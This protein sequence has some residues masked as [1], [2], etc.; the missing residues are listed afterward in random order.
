MNYRFAILDV[1]NGIAEIIKPIV[2]RKGVE[3]HYFLAAPQKGD[4][5]D[6]GKVCYMVLCCRFKA[7]SKK[8]EIDLYTDKS[9]IFVKRIGR[10][11]EIDWSNI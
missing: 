11:D 5:I 8:K 10:F 1:S 3:Y 7:Y 2:S 6:I 4:I 9:A